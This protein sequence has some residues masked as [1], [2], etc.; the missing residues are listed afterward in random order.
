MFGD[1]LRLARKKAGFSLRGL[2]DALD[3]EAAAQAI[4]KYERGAMM[5][6]S[7]VLI[8]LTRVLGVALQHL[9]SEQVDELEGVVSRK[10][11]STS[12]RDRALQ[13]HLT[14]KEILGLDNGAW[15]T[16][17]LEN[18]FGGH[19]DDGEVVA[20]DMRHEW[21]L[22]VGPIPNMTSLLKDR[23]VQVLVIALPRRGCRAH[24]AWSAGTAAV[25]RSR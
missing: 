11:S 24:P 6:S 12:A 22:G 23:G 18:R 20:D 13:R 3:G 10:L 9:L 8:R 5:P 19:D 2:S 25:A 17:R 21:R 16:L 7:K 4:G 15:R 1:R 14:I